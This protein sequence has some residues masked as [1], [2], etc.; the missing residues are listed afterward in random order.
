MKKINVVFSVI[1]LWGLILAACA[2]AAQPSAPQ[3]GATEPASVDS[4]ATEPAAAESEATEPAAAEP[5]AGTGVEHNTVPADPPD[6]GGDVLGDHSTLSSLNPGRALVGDRFSN[7]R[8]ERPYN[9]NTM[10]VYFPHLDLVEATF[11]TE[12]A[13]WV[14]AVITLVGRDENNTFPAK[15]AIELDL[16]QYGHG[17]FLILVDNP[18][19]TEWTTQGVYVY[20]DTNVDVGGE[21]AVLED[22]VGAGSDGYENVLF[23]QGTGDDPDLAWVRL[24]PNNPNSFQVAYK[25]SILGG[26]K[27]YTA[28]VW[29]GT[30]LDPALFDFND[31]MKHEDAG[32]ANPDIANFYP[33]KGLSELDN[34][35]R[36]GIGFNPS[37]VEP[38]ICVS[39]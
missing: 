24:D 6:S 8:F 23:D 15:Y 2:P 19:S 39:Q 12:D 33:I 5:E 14:Y 22:S 17:D 28:G 7:G 11:H 13:A 4:E 10:D 34:T 3:S 32:A 38:G 35:C 1:L 21:R 18:S 29:A 26:E 16:D 20:A 36:L 25:Q 9:A 31:H 30:E 37:G 27:T